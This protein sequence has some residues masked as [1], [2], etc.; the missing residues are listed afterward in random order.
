VTWRKKRSASRS[1]CILHYLDQHLTRARLGW[2]W[3][4][5]GQILPR[6]V[7]TKPVGFFR[8]LLCLKDT[9]ALPLVVLVTPLQVHLL[10]LTFLMLT[11]FTMSQGRG[12][13]QEEST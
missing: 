9:D 6:P 4:K 2:S 1:C 7:H 11:I 13:D 8:R 10:L 3:R 12:R 5:I